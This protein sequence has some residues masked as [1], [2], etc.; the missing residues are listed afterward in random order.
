MCVGGGGQRRWWAGRGGVPG[1]KGWTRKGIDCLTVQPGEGHG[2]GTAAFEAVVTG[3]AQAGTHDVGM[4]L[5]QH[6]GA[7]RLEPS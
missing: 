2:D 1:E 7:A 3:P 4:P 5:G 6:P